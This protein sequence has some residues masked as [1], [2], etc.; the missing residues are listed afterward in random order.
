MCFFQDALTMQR[1]TLQT[2][3]EL[4]EDANNGTPDVRALVQELL[5]DLFISTYNHQVS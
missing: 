2:K 4:S 1:M 5:T 3:L